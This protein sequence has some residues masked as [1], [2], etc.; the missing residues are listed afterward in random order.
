[1]TPTP[2]RPFM[3]GYGIAGP[4]EGTGLL[5]WSWAVERLKQSHD[6]WIA[7][8]RPDGRPHVMPVWGVWDDD[9]SL[10]F[11][12]SPG[13]RKTRNLAADPR[14]TA[15]TDNAL[16]PVI[17]EGT[18]ARVHDGSAA[19]RFT[20]AVNEKYD[21]TYGVEF[22]VENALFQLVPTWAFGLDEADFPGTPTRWRF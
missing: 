11:S 10:W 12:S 14:C 15:T 16:E 3:P 2:S 4:E 1:M 18:V 8:V 20:D 5:P 6:Y 7:T 22:F 19:R 13:S 21:E 17:V 9:D